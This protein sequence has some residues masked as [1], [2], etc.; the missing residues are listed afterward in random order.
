V[1][2]CICL[3]NILVCF[4]KGEES[5]SKQQIHREKE[6]PFLKLQYPPNKAF[7]SFNLSMVSFKGQKDLKILS[8]SISGK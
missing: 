1:N 4:L 5:K 2:H 3:L 6:M 8:Q 7:I